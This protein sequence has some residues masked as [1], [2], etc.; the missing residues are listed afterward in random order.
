MISAISTRTGMV[1]AKI[2]QDLSPSIW[3]DEFA[4]AFGTQRL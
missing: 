3:W 4:T 2:A 1:L